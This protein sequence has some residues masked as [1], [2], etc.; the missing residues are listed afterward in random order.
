MAAVHYE[1][2]DGPGVRKILFRTHQEVADIL[3]EK[4]NEAIDEKSE[5]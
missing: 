1:G 2:E 4:W 3:V 5:T